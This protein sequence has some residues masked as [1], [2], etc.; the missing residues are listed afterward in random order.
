MAK[1]LF[2]LLIFTIVSCTPCMQIGPKPHSIEFDLDQFE[3]IANYFIVHESIDNFTL[4]SPLPE[5]PID[6]VIAMKEIGILEF[7]NFGDH[8]VFFCGYG[9]VGKGWGFI[10]GNFSQAQI[11]ELGWIKNKEEQLLLTYLAPLPSKWYRFAV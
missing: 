4:K 5:T 11:E 8:K 10:Y 7:R 2:L 9:V 6:I 1:Q 3:L